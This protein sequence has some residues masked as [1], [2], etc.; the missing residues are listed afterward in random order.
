MY[1]CLCKGLTESDVQQ[2]ARTGQVCPE[3]L[4]MCF[5]LED[6]DCCGRCAKNIYELVAIANSAG[7]LTSEL[8]ML[9]QNQR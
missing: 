5:G 2:A 3:T 9:P 1:V 8:P 4:K 6:D 7:S